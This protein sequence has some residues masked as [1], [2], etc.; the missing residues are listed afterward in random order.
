[1]VARNRPLASLD[2]LYNNAQQSEKTNKRRLFL[3]IQ[4]RDRQEGTLKSQDCE[5]S[6]YLSY[7]GTKNQ[8][9]N[10]GRLHFATKLLCSFVIDFTKN[11]FEFIR[12]ITVPCYYT[13]L[14]QAI[15]GS[16][17]GHFQVVL[18]FVSLYQQISF[19]FLP[20]E[21]ILYINHPHNFLRTQK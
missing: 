2:A 18:I 11:Q 5:Q 14:Y 20:I 6:R 9:L 4:Y 13:I 7:A 17:T 8:A 10:F 16:K 1:M 12:P 3:R 19:P 21:L 15:L